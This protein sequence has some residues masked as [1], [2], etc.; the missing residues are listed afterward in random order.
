M[1]NKIIKILIISLLNGMLLSHSFVTAELPSHNLEVGQSF[2]HDFSFMAEDKVNGTDYSNG[3]FS[4][5]VLDI[6]NQ[7][8]VETVV[9]SITPKASSYQVNFTHEKGDMRVPGSSIIDG[10]QELYFVGFFFVFFGTAFVPEAGNFKEGFSTG[11]E[12][13]ESSVPLFATND[14]N[15][16]LEI[17]KTINE[18]KV[19]LENYTATPPS[20][21]ELVYSLISIDSNIDTSNRLF[22]L[23]V[24]I[25]YADKSNDSTV[26]WSR[27]IRFAFE[28]IIDYNQSV[29]TRLYYNLR[30]EVIYEDASLLYA[31]SLTV[32]SSS[33]KGF[34][35]NI[36]EQVSFTPAF[37]FV[38]PAAI[39][40][41]YVRRAKLK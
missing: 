33:G 38:F 8:N 7:D 4:P 36:R 6:L 31:Q 30:Y 29:V 32:D 16:Y 28:L 5:E 13:K 26:D 22:N 37:L 10:W 9:H 17:I 34:F 20:G 11:D 3:T 23:N 2:M 39:F 27:A 19:D 15:S 35:D 1:K 24:E 25:D 21:A 41:V 14:E 40:L 12:V 18:D